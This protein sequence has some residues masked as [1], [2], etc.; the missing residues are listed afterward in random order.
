MISQENLVE[1]KMNDLLGNTCSCILQ[2]KFYTCLCYI[3]I[4]P[5]GMHPKRLTTS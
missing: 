4:L 1:S 5:S 3:F 2:S